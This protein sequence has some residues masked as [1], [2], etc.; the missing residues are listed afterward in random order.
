MSGATAAD[1]AWFVK[2]CE[3]RSDGFCVTFVRDLSPEESLHRI[4]ATLGDISGEWGIEACATSGGTVLIDYGYAELPNL[5]SRGTATAR[6]F[7]NGSLDEDFV[8]SV[9]G[10]VVT[11]FEPCFPD[12][13]RGSDPDRL[14]AHMRELGMP[15]DEEAPDY[16]PTRIMGVLALAERATGVHL[17]PACYAMPTIVG[18]IDHLY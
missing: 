12:S 11:K 17:S 1:Y 15:V 3:E 4:G 18:S 7:T 8:Y 6:V 14:L 2:E 13:R 16:F 10:V 9:D 5:L